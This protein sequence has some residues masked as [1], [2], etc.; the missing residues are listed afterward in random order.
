MCLLEAVAWLAGEPHSDRPECACGVLAAY[1]R[2]LN[3]VM[4]EGAGGDAL[5]ARYLGDIAP[6]LV[7]TRSTPEVE[8]RRAYLLADRAVR[9]IA[10]MALDAA[11]L[12]DHAATLRGL[13]PVTDEGTARAA[14]AVAGAA[15]WAAVDAAEAAARAAGA[16]AEAAAWAAY[17]AADAAAA[18]AAARAAAIAAARVAHAAARVADPDTVWSEARRALI[19]AIQISGGDA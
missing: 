15:A 8:R 16:A 17:A 13:D 2:S 1:G 10:P 18:W 14:K 12:H 11:G 5:R 19:D 4:G 6:M 3:D 7:G 9:V